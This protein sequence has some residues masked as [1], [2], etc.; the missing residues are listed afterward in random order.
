MKRGTYFALVALVALAAGAQ[1][2]TIGPQLNPPSPTTFPPQQA[3]APVSFTQSL[4][5]TTIDPN[6]SVACGVAGVSTS[7][8]FFGRRFLLSGDHGINT[9]LTVLSLDIGHSQTDSGS[10]GGPDI[11]LSYEL[12]T[13][14]N[15]AP[16]TFGALTLI[17]SAAVGI[18]IGSAPALAN[19]PVAGFVDDP[20]GKDLVVFVHQP[21]DGGAAADPY[22]YRP[23]MNPNGQTGPT[24]IAAGACGINEP[25]DFAAIGFPDSQLLL[26]VNG[27]TEDSTPV[28]ETTWARVKNLYN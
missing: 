23:A 6:V 24:Y 10:G 22:Q 4:D 16:I 15:G 14:A 5:T 1:A 28:E 17:G 20:V 19:I 8:N 21:E 26:V 9:P 27:Q 25:T 7:E 11:P 3:A 12:Y 18:P 2:A 13:I